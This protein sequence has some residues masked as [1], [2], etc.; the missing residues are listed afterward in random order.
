[1]RNNIGLFV[2]KRAVMQPDQEAIIDLG[3]GERF[4]YRA[5]DERSNRLGNSLL[6]Q[7]LVKGDRV[8]TLLANCSQFVE[9][10]FGTAKVGGVV[11]PL[12]W[13]LVA[14]ELSFIL[15]D[16][17][18]ETLIFGS[19]LAE[20]VKELHARG[21]AGT[22]VQHWIHVG[23]ASDR[24]DFAR[25]YE[26]LLDA[27]S[28]AAP[29]I[30][31]SD[32][33]LLFIM[34]TSG[35]TGLP[36]GV[37]HSH[38]TTLWSSLTSL[39]TGDIRYDDRYLIALPLFHVGALNPLLSSLHRGGSV[40]ILPGFD[41]TRI[42]EIYAE[43]RINITLAVPAMLNFML[44]TYDANVHDTSHLRWIMSGAA[45]VPATLIE[46]YAG[47]GIDVVQVYGLTETCGPACLISPDDAVA[48]AGS[49]GKA[50]FHTDVKVVDADGNEI[51]AEET[52]E[53]LV[54][55]P[56]VM[57]GYWN[58]PDATAETIVDGWLHT[59]DVAKV[60]QDGYVYIQDR[61]KD[62]IISGG[63]NVYP[64]EIEN[65]ISGMDAVREV[66]VIGV[67]S[68]KWGESPLAIVVKADE[69]LAA[70]AVLDHCKGKL[71][72]FKLPKA[73]EF[74]DEIP[75]NPTGKVLKRVLREQFPG[76]A[77]N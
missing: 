65:V 72:P 30:G 40:A 23:R 37:M 35:T 63:E 5:L 71:A 13:R 50:F 21:A 59:G 26:D 36:K 58:R 42:W 74:V 56:H 34:Y 17:G 24:P 54:R 45:P 8:A 7:G 53:V 43:E 1:M 46:K 47:M 77:E 12:N 15:T 6:D 55:G 60:D 33:D 67:P 18:A 57:Q 38:S 70:Q 2:S 19:D 20:V 64:A 69:S 62:M 27:A 14:D 32:D 68:A 76:P 48:R 52:G 75:R 25:S 9:I 29:E 61:I 16:S 4:T 66:A 31:A 44:A 22:K 49:T 28:E 39:I 11:V 73:C 51:A 10:F 3:S 41:P